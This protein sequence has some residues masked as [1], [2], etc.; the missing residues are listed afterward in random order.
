MPTSNTLSK[1]RKAIHFFFSEEGFNN[2]RHKAGLRVKAF[3]DEKTVAIEI[4]RA[5]CLYNMPVKPGIIK[6]GTNTANKT[7]VVATT[8][9]V[10]SI[11]AS[12]T[13]L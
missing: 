8:G 2:R 9:P 13:A 5:N 6:V 10:I 1:A 4:V 7:A 3:S 12:V 11:I